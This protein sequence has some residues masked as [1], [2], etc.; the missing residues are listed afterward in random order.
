MS[1]NPIAVPVTMFRVGTQVLSTDVYGAI[2]TTDTTQ[3]AQGTTKKYTM[4]Q[5]QNY[6][7]VALASSYKNSCFVA[8][9]ANLTATYA[10]GTSGVGA[11]L[12]NSSTLAA[13]AIDGQSPAVGARILVKNQT[14]A[15]ENG[16]YVVTNVGSA[17]VAWILT[18][19]SDYD[20]SIVNINQGD[21]VGVTLGTTNG[22]SLWFQTAAGPF[23]M[24]TTNIV[25][26]QSV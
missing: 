18:R 11:T 3:S 15:F 4:A 26:T 5:L 2:D 1:N 17:S 13:L 24:G 19:S 12:T 14:S 16:I 25:F 20:Q 21:I 8:T 23:V 6:I 7:H 22:L 10:N 9:T